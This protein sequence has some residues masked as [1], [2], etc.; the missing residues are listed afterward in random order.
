MDTKFIK[1]S[2]IQKEFKIYSSQ[3]DYENLFNSLSEEIKEEL[4]LLTEYYFQYIKTQLE[5]LDTVTIKI[6]HDKK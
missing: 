3:V 2:G 5:N 4:K 1:Y 6:Y